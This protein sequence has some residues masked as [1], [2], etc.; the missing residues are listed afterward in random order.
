MCTSTTRKN[1]S[2]S[3]SICLCPNFCLNI[4]RT[5][6][7][8]WMDEWM[9]GI[10]ERSGRLFV[11]VLTQRRDRWKLF[12]S[13]FFFWGLSVDGSKLGGWL[14]FFFKKSAFLKETFHK[15]RHE[16]RRVALRGGES[17][18]D[19]ECDCFLSL[20]LSLSLLSRA[21]ARTFAFF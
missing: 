5:Q 12:F 17:S 20:S 10:S 13:F 8:S 19:G 14:V 15:G 9:N 7:R 4:Y 3:R 16:R 18:H 6:S 1:K 21:H 11:F 2:F